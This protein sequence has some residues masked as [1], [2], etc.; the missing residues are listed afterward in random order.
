VRGSHDH[1]AKAHD[2]HRRLRAKLHFDDHQAGRREQPPVVVAYANVVFLGQPL[3]I[4]FS[5]VPRVLLVAY[6][7]RVLLVAEAAELDQLHRLIV[8]GPRKA[9][10]CVGLGLDFRPAP[11]AAVRTLS[12]GSG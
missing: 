6:Q 7:R 8:R 9:A 1:A 12:S 3:E 4:E 2:R 5:S 11:P 10:R